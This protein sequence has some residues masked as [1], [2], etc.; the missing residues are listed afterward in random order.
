MFFRVQDFQGPVPGFRISRYCTL[1]R[2]MLT[3]VFIVS[4][5]F[6]IIAIRGC[7]I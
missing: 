7:K 3:N 1:P 2:A 6:A 4:N 5:I